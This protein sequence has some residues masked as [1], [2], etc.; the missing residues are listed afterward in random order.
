[1]EATI[2]D[3]KR[4]QDE[5]IEL[6]AILQVIQ[7]G[8]I[9]TG[10]DN[11]IKLASQKA[12]TILKTD[13]SNL[14]GQNIE[15][16]LPTEN[17]KDKFNVDLTTELKLQN[18]ETISATVKSLPVISQGELKGTVYIVHDKTEEKVFEEMKLN[19]VAMAAH[20][21]RTPLTFLKGYLLL[22]SESII[23][24]L[25]EHEKRY[26]DRSLS[27]VNKLSSL[28]EYLINATIVGE[29]KFNLNL[30]LSSL[31]HIVTEVITEF[32]NI[33][34]QKEIEINFEGPEIPLPEIMIDPYL[35]ETVLDNLI[36]NAIEHSL[37]K[38]ITIRARKTPEEVIVEV[39]DYGKGI[40]GYALDFLF[41]K[42]YKVP[43]HLLASPGSG[44]GLYISRLIIEAHHGKIWVNSVFGRGS[45]LS[46]ALPLI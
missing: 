46:F 28:T 43:N 35:I 11:L 20:Q 5:H 24:K 21:L 10:L 12:A 27:G 26:M 6:E 42:F 37:S 31:E 15:V 13:I 32:E 30:K 34:S 18:G 25:T 33:S 4:F 23:N 36:I 44:L 1:M 22:L 14:T 9:I 29:S 38:K 3:L 8:V 17:L 19:F 7:D 16:I 39:Q 40:P 2:E 41:T 45:I